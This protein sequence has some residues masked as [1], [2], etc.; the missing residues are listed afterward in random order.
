MTALNQVTSRSLQST[1][2]KCN[3]TAME[4]AQFKIFRYEGCHIQ[5]HLPTVGFIH[6]VDL[7]HGHFSFTL[8]FAVKEKIIHHEYCC[9]WLLTICLNMYFFAHVSY[10]LSFSLICKTI[11]YIIHIRCLFESKVLL[12]DF[13]IYYCYSFCDVIYAQIYFLHLNIVEKFIFCFSST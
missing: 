1:F 7:I 10:K 3:L 8:E 4:N 12:F 11:L 6:L 9:I 13:N 2:L 5:V